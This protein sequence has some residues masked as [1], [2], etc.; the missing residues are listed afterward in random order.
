[1]CTTFRGF[2]KWNISKNMPTYPGLL[3]SYK[4]L[5]WHHITPF[6]AFMILQ[7]SSWLYPC[8]SHWV[9]EDAA[10]D[11]TPGT[12][13]QM[14]RKLCVLKHFQ[15]CDNTSRQQYSWPTVYCGFSYNHCAFLQATIPGI[16]C[17]PLTA[18]L[19]TQSHGRWFP[20]FIIAAGVNFVGAI[21]YLSQSAA[22]Q[23]I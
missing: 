5:L 3:F 23:V 15:R 1:M 22:S 16:T 13:T 7:N 17:G 2:G 21:I 14:A 6:D 11:L 8:M 12:H 19:V 4:F 20:V 10:N 9:F 18:E